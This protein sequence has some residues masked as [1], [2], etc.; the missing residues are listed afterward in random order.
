MAD[1]F[2]KKINLKDG[3]I[4]Q[5]PASPNPHYSSWHL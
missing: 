5:M 1:F 2:N 3:Q 4:Y